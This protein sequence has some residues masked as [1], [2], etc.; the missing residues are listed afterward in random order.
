MTLA[1]GSFALYFLLIKM[2][3]PEMKCNKKQFH[4]KKFLLKMNHS[5]AKKH[6]KSNSQNFNFLAKEATLKCYIYY[7]SHWWLDMFLYVMD[8]FRASLSQND[9]LVTVIKFISK[10]ESF[11]KKK[12]P[13]FNK[14]FKIK[15]TLLLL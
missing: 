4:I 11:W 7:C 2:V 6:L 3:G 13:D 12:A 10:S 5:H 1:T 15:V 9:F 8:A 14:T